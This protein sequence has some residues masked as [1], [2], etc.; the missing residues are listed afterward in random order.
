MPDDTCS[1]C[2]TALPADLAGVART[3]CPTCGSSLRT[4]SLSGTASASASATANLTIVLY[5][6]SLLALAKQLCTA[7][8]YGV[9]VVVAHIACEVAVMR[10]FDRAF[11][12]QGLEFLQDAVMAFCPGYNLDN[13]RIRRLYTS[14]TKDDIASQ[15]FWASFSASAQRRSRMVHEGSK[16]TPQEA[17]DSLKVVEAFLTH[18][19]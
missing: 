5:Q 2:A 16:P 18:V 15:P 9:A 13:N 14:L 17:A 3:P 19:G 6:H 8:E 10:A 7:G 11:T 4:V 12:A 1:V